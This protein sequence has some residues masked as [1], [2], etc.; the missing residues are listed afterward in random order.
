[1]CKLTGDI[2]HCL[3]VD[4]FNFEQ[5]MQLNHTEVRYLSKDT[6]DGKYLKHIG[7]PRCLILKRT[8]PVILLKN[9]SDSLTNG[10]LGKVVDFSEE[11]PVI[12]FECE[13]MTTQLKKELFTGKQNHITICKIPANIDFLDVFDE[14]LHSFY[15]EPSWH[16]TVCYDMMVLILWGE[17]YDGLLIHPLHDICNIKAPP[18][19]NYEQHIPYSWKWLLLHDESVTAQLIYTY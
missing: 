10:T 19:F 9:L 18:A 15:I 12:H 3:Q 11:G 13:D 17:I 7:A 5:I 1:M 16:H 8:C 2:F 14:L 4:R 6:G